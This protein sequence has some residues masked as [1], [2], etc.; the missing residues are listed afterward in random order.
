MILLQ[1]RSCWSDDRMKVVAAFAATCCPTCPVF[2]TAGRSS[3][4]A[5]R[6]ESAAVSSTRKLESNWQ[7]MKLKPQGGQ[8]SQYAQGP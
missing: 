2:P 1:R 7:R 6:R 8:R 5:I 4:S 3:S